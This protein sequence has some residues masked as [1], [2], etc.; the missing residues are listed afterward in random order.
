MKG[1]KLFECTSFQAVTLLTFSEL[2][3]TELRTFE[4][5]QQATG[6]GKNQ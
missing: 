6:M 4:E 5:I 3:S 2:P 1:N